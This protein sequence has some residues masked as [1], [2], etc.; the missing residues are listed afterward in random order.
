MAAMITMT[1]PKKLKLNE[2]ISAARGSTLRRCAVAIA[3]QFIP[4]VTPLVTKSPSGTRN[5]LNKVSP[6][7]TPQIPL[8]MV[9]T[10]INETDPSN[11]V[12]IV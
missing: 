4:M 12:I 9:H 1:V 11:A 7:K 3:P 10:A 2:L 6:I 5:N 8:R